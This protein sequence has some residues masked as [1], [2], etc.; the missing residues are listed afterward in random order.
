MLSLAFLPPPSLFT[1]FNGTVIVGVPRAAPACVVALRAYS[2]AVA[3]G[4]WL[5]LHNRLVAPVNNDVPIYS[6]LIRTATAASPEFIEL[7]ADFF[8]PLGARFT[9]GL[10][11]GFSSAENTYQNAGVLAADHSLHLLFR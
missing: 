6:L 5:Q 2:N 3:A 7:G 8:G 10:S 1:I 4:R 9:T 11:V